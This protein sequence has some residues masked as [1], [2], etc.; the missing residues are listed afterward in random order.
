MRKND[1][2]YLYQ[3]LQKYN[4]HSTLNNDLILKTKIDSI[5]QKEKDESSINI[6][7]DSSIPI[8][9]INKIH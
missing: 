5:I 3:K 6:N 4:T 7:K 1:D 2:N 8:I 9:L